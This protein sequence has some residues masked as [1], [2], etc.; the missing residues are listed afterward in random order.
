MRS[1]SVVN[2]AAM[3]DNN[4]NVLPSIFGSKEIIIIENHDAE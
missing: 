3:F 2:V 1:V 4:Y